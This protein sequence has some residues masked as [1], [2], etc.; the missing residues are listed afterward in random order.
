MDTATPEQQANPERVIPVGAPRLWTADY[1]CG[2]FG[3]EE[4][5]ITMSTLYRGIALARYPRPI[6]IGG[7]RWLASEC[8]ATL[9][10]MIDKRDAG[11]RTA[12]GRHSRSQRRRTRKQA[13]A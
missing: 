8:E 3:G 7:A 4:R 10:L 1:V 9:Q 6:D 5:P 11:V 2:F 12:R 13:G